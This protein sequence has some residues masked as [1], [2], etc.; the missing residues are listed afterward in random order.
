MQQPADTNGHPAWTGNGAGIPVALVSCR[1][2]DPGHVSDALNRAVEL[3]GGLDA[4]VR[5]GTRVLVKPNLLQGL[6]PEKAVCTHPA[7]MG[8]VIQLLNRHGCTVTVADSP[9]GGIR[10]TGKNL[11]KQ[12]RDAGYTRLSGI[13]ECTLNT[14]VG[15]R[16]LKFREGKV[17]RE[18]PIIDPFFSSD[19]VVVVS[20]AK[21]HILTLMTGATK[22]VFGLIPG[23]EKPLL[24]SRY[25]TG[26]RFG[27]MLIDLNLA[28]RPSFQVADAIL[29][30]EGDGPT[31]GAPRHVGV[32]LASPS[33]FAID[34]VLCRLMSVDPLDV[35]YLKCAIGRGLCPA[36]WRDL[37]V[38]GEPVSRFIC[39]DFQKPRTY[40]GARKELR[41]S[42]L[43]RAVHR[44]GRLY[45]MRPVPEVS[46][47]TGCGKC[48]ATCPVQAISISGGHARIRARTC[49]RCYCCH[50]MCSEGAI[51]LKR[52]HFASLIQKVAGLHE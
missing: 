7:V 27:D 24:H 44:L 46:R 43:F 10:F 8:A 41:V 23:L 9:G 35:P 39:P 40:Q 14:G 38:V 15:Y 4:F 16:T 12:Y 19:H 47:C 11:Q 3:V 42:P 45:S 2:Y 31:S 48:A 13:P 28:V 22:N 32:L 33:P 6:P 51:S 52:G 21:S 1:D 20:K 25:Q 30:M 29:A 50:E 17:C 37:R 36:D 34:L 26:E 5:S 18:F 49:I